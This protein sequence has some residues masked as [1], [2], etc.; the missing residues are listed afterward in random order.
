MFDKSIY[1]KNRANVLKAQRNDDLQ[2]L[3]RDVQEEG[4]RCMNNRD[5]G[6]CLFLAIADQLAHYGFIADEET[7]EQYVAK[8]KNDGEYGDVRIFG[9]IC[10]LYNIKIKIGKPVNIV[11]EDGKEGKPVIEL[12]YVGHIHYI[13]IRKD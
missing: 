5:E 7:L 3:I 6:D 12:A 10:D 2:T 4:A 1:R 11:F 8:M 13:S 9:A